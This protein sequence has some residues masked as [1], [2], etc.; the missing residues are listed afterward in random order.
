MY[1][2]QKLDIMRD[3]LRSKAT[4]VIESKKMVETEKV[5]PEIDLT[6]PSTTGSMSPV[7]SISSPQPEEETPISPQPQ[8]E[9]TTTTTTTDSQVAS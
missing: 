6:S 1:E 5:I 9:P 2:A 4:Y 3:A 8:D 7:S